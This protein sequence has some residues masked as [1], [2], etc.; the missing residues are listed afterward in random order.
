[1]KVEFICERA[2]PMDIDKAKIKKVV[3]ESSNILA[4][5]IGENMI[6]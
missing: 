3:D 5:K 4:P 2:Y 1:M 6:L